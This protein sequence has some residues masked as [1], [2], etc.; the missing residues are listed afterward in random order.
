MA[1]PASKKVIFAALAGNSIIAVIKFAAAAITGSSAML[2]EAIHSV[3]DTGN[4]VLLLYGIRAAA[5]R[6]DDSHPFGYGMELYFWT[7]VVAILIFALGSGISIY[8]GVAK[9]LEPHPINNPE[10][11][12]LVLGAA[13]IFEGVAWSIAVK[14]FRKV[15]GNRGWI[16]EV[17]HSKDPTIF[18]V[19]FA[20][21]IVKQKMR[22]IQ[23]LFFLISFAGIV[24][25]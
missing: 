24:V 18:T 10:I 4:Q 3:V 21:Y 16:E 17:R 15:K 11:N 12:Y 23:W 2:S 5:R 6:P 13:M 25:I 22:P 9:V 8:E 19:L 20:I 1:T 7:F 14:E